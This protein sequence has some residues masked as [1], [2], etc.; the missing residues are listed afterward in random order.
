M[1]KFNISI[2]KLV[3]ML[4]YL[5]FSDKVPL[6]FIPIFVF[7][8]II[9]EWLSSK[10]IEWWCTEYHYDIYREDDKEKSNIYYFYVEFV[11]QKHGYFKE[12]KYVINENFFLDY[13]KKISKSTDTR[14]SFE[15]NPTFMPGTGSKIEFVHKDIKVNIVS[16]SFLMQTS[17]KEKT[18]RFF[19]IKAK[20]YSQIEK[21]MDYLKELQPEFIDSTSEKNTYKFFNYD[22][23]EYKWT[24]HEINVNK[25]F[26]NIF[27]E[28]EKKSS[29]I[30]IVNDFLYNKDE[31]DKQGTPHKLGI[32]LHGIPGNGKSS[33]VY[34]IAKTHGK[35]IYRVNLSCPK[36]IFVKQ[37]S[38][39]NEKSIVLFD[40]IDTNRISHK[41][42]LENCPVTPSKTNLDQLELGDILEILDGY[43]YFKDCIIIMITNHYEKLDPALIRSGRMDHKIEFTNAGKE[44][45][46]QIMKF[47]FNKEFDMDIKKDISVSELINT[48]IIPHRNDYEYVVNYLKE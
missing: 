14:S 18:V 1:N 29:L 43:C 13:S 28:T 44:Q 46:S 31:Y 22:M 2:N 47:F 32:L 4:P 26:D 17:K 20:C 39:I 6:Y 11:L 5:I 12:I 10:F 25:T 33:I 41:R 21:F 24:I 8:P 9:F 30:K 16:G 34:A 7:F 38:S 36:S 45:I 3:D 37:I 15:T 40:D 27:L 42:S 48:I 19:R 23:V 35:N